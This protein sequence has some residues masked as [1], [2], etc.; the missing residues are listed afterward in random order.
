MK[1]S[2]AHVAALAFLL[3]GCVVPQAEVNPEGTLEVFSAASLAPGLALPEYVVDTAGGRIL[4]P[5]FRCFEC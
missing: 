5:T 3:C 1:A 4:A 2:L